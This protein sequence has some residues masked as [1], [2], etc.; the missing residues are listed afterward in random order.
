MGV[1]KLARGNYL[2]AIGGIKLQACG[3]LTHIDK[4]INHTPP[5]KM[6]NDDWQE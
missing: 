4:W 2:F 1:R 3:N 6:F 5:C